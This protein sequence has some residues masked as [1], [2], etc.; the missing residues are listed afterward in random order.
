MPE[1]HAAE[2]FKKAP[3]AACPRTVKKEIILFTSE[4]QS[5]LFEQSAQ[6]IATQTGQ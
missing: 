2:A 5:V 6:H 1:Q 3:A 4:L